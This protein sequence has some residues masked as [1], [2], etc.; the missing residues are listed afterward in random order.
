MA[1]YKLLSVALALTTVVSAALP[2]TDYDVIVV[3][4]GPAGLSVLSGLSR[5]RRRTA[6]FDSHHYRN[7]PTREMHDVIGNDG[8]PPADFRAAARAQISNYPTASFIDNAIVSITPEPADGTTLFRARDSSGAQYTARKVVLATGLIDLLPATPGLAEAFGKGIFWCPWCDG[9]EHRDQPFGILGTL[10][11]IVSSVVE[12]A[13]LNTD[14]IAFVNGSY[15][16]DE[17]STLESSYPDWRAQMQ[18][19]N[20]RIENRTIDSI[21]R[22]QDGGEVQNEAQDQQLDIFQINFTEGDPVIRNA[23]LTNFDTAQRSSIPTD[24]GLVMDDGK[25]DTSINTGMR[26]SLAG[27]FAVG[28]CNNDGST[29]VPHAMFSGKRAA[30]FG[31]VELAREDMAAAVSKRSLSARALQKEA[32]RAMGDEMERIWERVRV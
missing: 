17:V 24:L 18:A 19:Y 1:L 23:L 30:V 3:G 8:T 9:Y 2:P 32:E 15:T 6:L 14:I 7:D 5:V 29:N 26:T 12:V 13:T 22:L 11:H 27:V 10:P 28:D 21:T 4:G 25:I 31:H 16:P 20:V